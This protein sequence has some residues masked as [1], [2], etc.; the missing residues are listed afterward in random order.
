MNITKEQLDFLMDACKK[1]NDLT[2]NG[3]C[4]VDI[5]YSALNP[6][7]ILNDW[8]E[9]EGNDPFWDKVNNCH[10]AE[11]FINKTINEL[12]KV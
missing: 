8:N 6:G 3:V 1:H 4:I 5:L 7:Y 11:S 2:N 12:N 9:G 10:S